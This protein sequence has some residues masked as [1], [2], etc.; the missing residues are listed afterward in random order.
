MSN[1]EERKTAALKVLRKKNTALGWPIK[2]EI[3]TVRAKAIR[4]GGYRI[5]QRDDRKHFGASTGKRYY[6]HFSGASH[7]HLSNRDL[8]ERAEIRSHKDAS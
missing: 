6:G 4:S 5:S 8:R 2:E 3:P 7:T 1:K